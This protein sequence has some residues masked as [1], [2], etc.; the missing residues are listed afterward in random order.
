MQFSLTLIKIEVEED[1]LITEV[2]EESEVEESLLPES[3]IEVLPD[4]V[5]KMQIETF[6]VKGY[7]SR[8][9]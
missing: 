7:V 9:F 8:S 5:E 2:V 4:Y 3:G 6:Y 1:I